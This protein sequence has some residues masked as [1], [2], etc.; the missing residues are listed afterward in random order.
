MMIHG[1][2]LIWGVILQKRFQGSKN[3]QCQNPNLFTETMFCGHDRHHSLSVVLKMWQ[4]R[5]KNVQLA[6]EKLCTLRSLLSFAFEI[7]L[8]GCIWIKKFCWHLTYYS[9]TVCYM[10]MAH[11]VIR[12]LTGFYI[13]F[14][15]QCPACEGSVFPFT[16]LNWRLIIRMFRVNPSHSS[17]S[18]IVKLTP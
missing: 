4:Y 6:R 2:L 1:T 14:T 7:N 5:Q 10:C 9:A 3:M 17:S 13:L 8:K 18:Y 11:P 16:V 12:T 15:Y